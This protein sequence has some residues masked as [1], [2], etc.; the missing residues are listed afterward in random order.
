MAGTAI[1]RGI[2]LSLLAT[3][4]LLAAIAVVVFMLP[5]ML[6]AIPFERVATWCWNRLA[7]HAFLRTASPPQPTPEPPQVTPAPLPTSFVPR[8]PLNAGLALGRDPKTFAE[9]AAVRKF[10]LMKP[11]GRVS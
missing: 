11:K 2:W 7:P 1:W 5:G 3:V 9:L 6:L 4:W 8:H 10:Q